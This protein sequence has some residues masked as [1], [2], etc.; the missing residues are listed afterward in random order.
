VKR[1]HRI[2][3]GDKELFE[4]LGRRDP[5][6]CGSGRKFQGMLPYLTL[7]S[8][9]EAITNA[10]RAFAQELGSGYD[11]DVQRETVSAGWP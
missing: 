7:V 10:E 2:V 5:C 9:S 3:H 4:K 6:P 1:D 8:S 11:D